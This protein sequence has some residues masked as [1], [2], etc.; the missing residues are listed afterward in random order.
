MTSEVEKLNEAF[1][2][3]EQDEGEVLSWLNHKPA[4]ASLWGNAGERPEVHLTRSGLFVYSVTSMLSL[5]RPLGLRLLATS[6]AFVRQQRVCGC[7]EREES[8]SL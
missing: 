2:R 3:G 6:A 4:L 7:P 8:E 1:R 5:H